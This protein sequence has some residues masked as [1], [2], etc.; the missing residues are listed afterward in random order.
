MLVITSTT[1]SSF[2]AI[3]QSFT[4]IQMSTM[5]MMKSIL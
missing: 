2:L 1:R 3:L 5:P 4:A